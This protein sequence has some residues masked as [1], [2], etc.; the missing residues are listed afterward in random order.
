VKLLA[1]PYAARSELNIQPMSEAVKVGKQRTLL[2]GEAA[3][4]PQPAPS[5]TALGLRGSVL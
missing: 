4:Q 3:S 5:T 1:V 2:G